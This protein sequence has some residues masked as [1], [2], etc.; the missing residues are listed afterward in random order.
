MRGATEDFLR[1]LGGERQ[2]AAHTLSAYRRDLDELERFLTE[3]NG[4]PGW[5][6]SDVDRLTLRSFLGW[7]KGRSLARKSVARKLSAV[8]SFLRFL[9]REERIA[10]NPA[11]GLR[12]PKGERRLP[13]C[14]GRREID[15]IFEQ[16]EG[17]AAEN[18]LEGT[19]TLVILEILYGS[20][21]RLSELQQLDWDALDTVRALVRVRGK[22]QKERVV[23]LTQAALR[24][25]DRY[26][27]RHGEVALSRG[28]G[29]VLVNRAG[30][31]LSRRTVQRTVRELIE[32]VGGG[33]DGLSVHSL[34]HSFATHLL[35]SGADLMAVKELLGHSSLSTTQTYVHTSMERLSRVYRVCHPRA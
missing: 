35:D 29:P 18:T 22:G 11:R 20:G 16:A 21:L 7:L 26:A 30:A 31:R 17:R 34:R 6:W 33:E 5:S 27:P 15:L 3:Y 19:R 8:R 9:H 23:P 13:G 24:A 14:L 2:L 10:R 12:S 4:T 28:A 1:H 32:V 25:L